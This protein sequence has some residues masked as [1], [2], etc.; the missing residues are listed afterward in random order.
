MGHGNELYLH[1]PLSIDSFNELPRYQCLLISFRADS[2]LVKN[3][4][5]KSLEFNNQNSGGVVAPMNSNTTKASL[6]I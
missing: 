3:Y 2:A 4:N 1:K 5:M 6:V